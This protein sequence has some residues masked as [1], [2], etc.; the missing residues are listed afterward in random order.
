MSE[1]SNPILGYAD[2]YRS[3]E[4]QGTKSVDIW[5][6]ITDLERN[7]A[8]LMA[9]AQSELAALREELAKARELSVTNIL[10]DVV[11]GK[12][13]EGY[14]VFAASVA[15]VCEKLG[16]LSLENETFQDRLTAAEQRNADLQEAAIS[17]RRTIAFYLFP[18]QLR[19]CAGVLS[20]LDALTKPTESGESE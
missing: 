8:P 6:V 1:E 9:A 5:S 18:S 2:S 14:E 10:L 20:K 4:R 12:D 7:M 17:A 13:G 11:R 19:A 15:H 16:E 3:M